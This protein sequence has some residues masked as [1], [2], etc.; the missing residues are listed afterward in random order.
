MKKKARCPITKAELAKRGLQLSHDT[1]RRLGVDELS[2]VAAGCDTGS[3]AT[4]R[5]TFRC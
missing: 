1:L 5:R 3:N 2:R 4:D